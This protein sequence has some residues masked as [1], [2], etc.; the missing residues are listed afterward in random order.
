M[1]RPLVAIPAYHLDTGRVRGWSAGGFGVP[2]R[3]ITCVEKAG[4]RGLL[5]P[6]PDA[7]GPITALEPFDG[8]LLI[9]GGDIDPARYGAAAHPSVYGVDPG[10]DELELGLVRAA[11]DAGVPVLAICRGF[12]VLNVALGGTLHQH[13]PDIE[14]W[15]VHGSPMSDPPVIHEVNIDAGSRIAKACGTD[16][17]HAA[18]HHHQGAD[19][20]GDGLTVT[21]WTNDELVEGIEL[22]GDGW[23][24]G[25]QW[26][27]EVTAAD[28]PQQQS[29][30]DAFIAQL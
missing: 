6:G 22:D 19:R 21:A 12:Q 28:D 15:A 7:E 10:R 16:A 3:Y 30:F 13:L 20:L 9:G 8:L 1:A 23:V 27:P 2:D 11:I 24:V 4:G 17:V 29:L 18:S 25:V 14:D 5:L 26:H